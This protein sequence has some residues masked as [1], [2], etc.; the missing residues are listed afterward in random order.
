MILEQCALHDD[1]QLL[2]CRT[3][4]VISLFLLQLGM[5]EAELEPED[6]LFVLT[7]F[8]EGAKGTLLDLGDIRADLYG[9]E[10]RSYL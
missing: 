1:L 5:V 6:E 10:K 2:L 3:L 9:Q 8:H 4:F 7:Q